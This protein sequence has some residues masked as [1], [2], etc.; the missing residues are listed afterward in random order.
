MDRR[1]RDVRHGPEFD[2]SWRQLNL[3]PKDLQALLVAV[4]WMIARTAEQCVS[5]SNGLRHYPHGSSERL[6]ALTFYFTIDDEKT[7]TLRFV[8]LA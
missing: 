1:L 6:P 8:R 3:N 2:I 5:D 4:K 7:Y